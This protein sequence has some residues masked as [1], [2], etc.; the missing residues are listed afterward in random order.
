[1]HILICC[2]LF[3]F[4]SHI[5]LQILKF[6]S[7][8]LA[9]LVLYNFIIPISLYVTVE[10]QKFLGSFFIGWDL[11][12]Y[13]EESDQKAQV[14]TSDLNEELGQVCRKSVDAY[15]YIY[16][17]PFQKIKINMEHVYCAYNNVIAVGLSIFSP[18]RQRRQLCL[19]CLGGVCLY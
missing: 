19:H 12:L 10:M 7:D 3:V 11:D 13:H 5:C 2:F 6:I 9:F 8:F 14:N 18:K 16:N 17:A 4:F 15:K 1:M